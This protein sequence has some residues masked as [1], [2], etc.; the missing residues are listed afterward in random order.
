MYVLASFSHGV[1]LPSHSLS[2]KVLHLFSEEDGEATEDE[3]LCFLKFFMKSYVT[4]DTARD[5]VWKVLTWFTS[6]S[7]DSPSHGRSMIP[8]VQNDP[9]AGR[10]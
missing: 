10:I 1:D 3:Y 8:S 6:P 2:P 4:S 7:Q 5:S 9:K